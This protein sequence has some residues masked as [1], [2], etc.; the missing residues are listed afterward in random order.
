VGAVFQSG[1]PAQLYTYSIYS[2]L[3]GIGFIGFILLSRRLL[4]LWGFFYLLTLVLSCFG[5][6]FALRDN[7]SLTTSFHLVALATALVSFGLLWRGDRKD[8]FADWLRLNTETVRP[9][10]SEVLSTGLLL[11]LIVVSRFHQLNFIPPI[12]ETE[13]CGTRPMATSWTLMVE[14]ELGL[15]SQQSSGMSWPLLHKLFTRTDDPIQ[16]DLD[17]RLLGVGISLISC[18]AVYF[19][20][21][22]LAGPFA[23]T[24]ALIIYGFGPLD[25]YWSRLP[26][27]HHL[28]VCAG[29]IFAWASFAAL[30]KR[31]WASFFVLAAL[32]MCTKFVYPS[33][34]MVF[35][36]PIFAMGAILLW[37]RREWLGQK[38]KLLV[39]ALA[40]ILFLSLPTILYA[41]RFHQF[42]L[43]VPF[44]STQRLHTTFSFG[45]T[46]ALLW[47]EVLK[48][49]QELYF[50]PVDPSH[51]T[52]H[53]TPAPLRSVPSVGVIF[54]TLVLVR[55]GFLARRPAA[56]LCLGLIV[57][58]AMPALL[59][60]VSDRRLSFILVFLPLLAIIELA[61]FFN[62]F[63]GPRLPRLSRVAKGIVLASIAVCLWSYQ[64][65]SLFS[66]PAARPIQHVLV[67]ELR[68]H[69]GT[70]T[71]VVNLSGESECAVFYGIYDLI[72]DSG[73]RVAY[74]FGPDLSLNNEVAIERPTVHT[75]NWRYR[76]TAL[77]DHV[78]ILKGKQEWPRKLYVLAFD[79]N[80]DDVKQKLRAW[81]PGGREIIVEKPGIIPLRATF[82]DTNP[83][84]P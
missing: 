58:G 21:R 26:P 80:R 22:F 3:F 45:T 81:Y 55:L 39:V 2:A 57:G 70:D 74:V 1:R 83:A 77:K 25:L 11:S 33:A 8:I 52:K 68:T 14:Q 72:R 71:L 64:T 56:L 12:W 32:M 67:E 54:M 66:S 48:I 18:W 20:M 41:V 82:F 62:N 16:F 43:M 49:F 44:V 69:V 47:N 23:A 28:P 10:V 27:H 38:R 7:R 50:A 19:F 75:D 51:F 6:L 37:D 4:S 17:S 73:G 42:H 15:Q 61:W 34:K 59:T 84:T 65:Q 53:V 78:D 63:L 36:G 46:I 35:L 31:T 40:L 13:M 79:S 24:L 60:G 29:I 76:L 9:G 30:S 5:E